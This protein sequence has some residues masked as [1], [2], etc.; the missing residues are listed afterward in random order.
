MLLVVFASLN[1]VA[2]LKRALN[3]EGVYVDMLRTPR[4]LS[5]TG[6]SF[7]VR[8]QPADMAPLLQA[9]RKWKIEPGGVFEETGEAASEQ[10]RLFGEDEE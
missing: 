8:C 1:Q 4:C 9:C 7:A 2:L 6:C 5:S 10:Y 3:R